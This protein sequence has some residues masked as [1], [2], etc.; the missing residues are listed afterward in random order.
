M[1]LGQELLS[2]ATSATISIITILILFSG[3]IILSYCYNYFIKYNGKKQ[4]PQYAPGSMI[5]HMQMASSPEYPWWI[6]E[7]AN[8]LQS[9]VFQVSMPPLRPLAHKVIVGDAQTARD[10]LT[11]PLSTKPV[12]VYGPFRNING[13]E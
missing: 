5:K 4:V 1:V 11:D 9:N 3:Y 8:Q 13:R 2:A 7:V 6:L 10:I 12:E